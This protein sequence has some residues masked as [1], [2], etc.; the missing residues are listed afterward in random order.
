[1]YAVPFII[2]L[3]FLPDGNRVAAATSD[4]DIGVWDTASGE[5]LQSEP[6]QSLKSERLPLSLAASSDG[7]FLA[8]GCQDNSVAILDL[9]TDTG[10]AMEGLGRN[11]DVVA[12]S[13]DGRILASTAY[14]EIRL[15][16]VPAEESKPE[17]LRILDGHE[18]RIQ[19]L[20]FSP[21]CR[22][23][24]SAS[25]DKTARIWGVKEPNESE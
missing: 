8:A 10:Y 2:R 6:L 22:L 24:A 15:W 11:V 20:A 3:V 1:M 21:D 23:L 13:P 9:Q 17:L 12:F 4:G 25:N 19:S 18:L 5:L 14:D 16:H 7:R